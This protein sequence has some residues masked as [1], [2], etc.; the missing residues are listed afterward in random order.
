[1][2]KS[3]SWDDRD[4][5]PGFFDLKELQ[6]CF[7]PSHNPPSHIY[8]PAGQGYRHICPTCKSTVTLRGSDVT[9]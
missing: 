9:M 4:Q 6:Q 5:K 3:S 1:M 8:I 2:I 7:D